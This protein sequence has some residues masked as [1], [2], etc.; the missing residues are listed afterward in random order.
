MLEHL[1]ADDRVERPLAERQHH[2]VREK[3]GTGRAAVRA[4]HCHRPIGAVVAALALSQEA[5]VRFHAAADIEQ[6]PRF[7]AVAQLPQRLHD[8]DPL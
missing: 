2:A 1:C 8:T 4:L 7:H 5:L 3:I 6:T